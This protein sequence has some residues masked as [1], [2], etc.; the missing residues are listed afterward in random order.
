MA[1]QNQEIISRASSVRVRNVIN[2]L[3]WLTA[4]T[5]GAG[6]PAV[7]VLRD[8]MTLALPILAVTLLSP[9]ATIAAYVYF[10][11]RDPQRLHSEEY[12]IAQQRLLLMQKGSSVAEDIDAVSLD[13]NPELPSLP[14]AHGNDDQ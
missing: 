8:D 12:L 6:L 10:M 2:P 3:L 7:I 11:A 5:L 1:E 4:V 13:T 14:E 9:L